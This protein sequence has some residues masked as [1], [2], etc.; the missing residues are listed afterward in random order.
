MYACVCVCMYAC[1]CV[2]VCVCVCACVCECARVCCMSV[3]QLHSLH[4]NG[5]KNESSFDEHIPHERTAMKS[6]SFTQQKTSI[7]R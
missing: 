3:L 5:L 7:L 6:Q 4:I 2:C 1:V